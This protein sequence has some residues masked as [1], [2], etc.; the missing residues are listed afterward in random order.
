MTG[1]G[2]KTNDD[3]CEAIVKIEIKGKELL[4]VATGNGPVNALDGALRMAIEPVFP[5]LKKVELTDY[6]VR[7]LN[8]NVGTAMATEVS[9]TMRCGQETVVRIRKSENVVRA[10]LEA[11]IAGMTHFIG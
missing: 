6:S 9:I 1:Y 11:L 3:A 5:S 10:S 8:H 7:A 2:H 4:R